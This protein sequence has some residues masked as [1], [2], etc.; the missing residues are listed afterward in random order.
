MLHFAV[1]TAWGK[2]NSCCRLQGLR[3]HFFFHVS[4][5]Y[6]L[7]SV[8]LHVPFVDVLRRNSSRVSKLSPVLFAPIGTS[9]HEPEHDMDGSTT[10]NSRHEVGKWLQKGFRSCGKSA[11]MTPVEVKR[12]HGGHNVPRALQVDHIERRWTCNFLPSNNI[13]INLR[14]ICVLSYVSWIF[15]SEVQCILCN[16]RMQYAC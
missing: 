8:F 12:E 4:W 7:K 13:W 11:A 16:S 15:S 3:C 9:L 1:K 10:A 2:T 5:F 6:L 14:C